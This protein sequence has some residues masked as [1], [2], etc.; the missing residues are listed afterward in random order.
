MYC[1]SSRSFK[2]LVQLPGL[3]KIFHQLSCTHVITPLLDIFVPQLVSSALKNALKEEESDSTKK[4]LLEIIQGLLTDIE[5]EK[6]SVITIG[7]LDKT[8]LINFTLLFKSVSE[9]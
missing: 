2:A 3:M 9:C 4:P 6:D 7:R 8:F 1:I 5:F